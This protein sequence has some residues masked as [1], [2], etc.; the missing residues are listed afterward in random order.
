M[1]DRVR[2][3]L[4]RGDLCHREEE[5][6]QLMGS[7][8]TKLVQVFGIE[9]E[10]TAVLVTGSGTAALEMA[11]SSCLTPKKSMLIVQNGVYGE[12]IA[13][14]AEVYHFEKHVLDYPWGT[15]PKLSDIENAFREHLD[16][17]VVA[18][19][20]HET[21]T[22]LLNPIGPAGELARRYG[23]K[24][25]VD[26]IS[27]LGGDAVDFGAGSIDMAVGTANKCIQG[28]P[29]VS[30]VLFRK[31]DLCRLNNIP[32]RSCYFNLVEHHKA[33]ESGNT[34]FTPAVQS[35]YALE[36]ALEELM[37]ETTAGRIRRYHAAAARFRKG[38]ADMGL[39]CLIPE[40]HRSN[41][42]TALRLPGGL[43]YASLHD[44]LKEKGFVIYAG[45]GNLNSKIFRIANMGNIR[46]GEIDRCLQV[47]RECCAEKI[48]MQG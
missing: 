48:Q 15:P 12:R 46:P 38:F 31:K 19:V 41:C 1:T 27:S 3:A 21:T 24:F 33:Q 42:L 7:I 20:H 40:A 22:G 13:K 39:E 26:C 6:A 2:N 18:M 25:L 43:S 4:L 45:Q 17:E 5:F 9:D 23:K 28:L 34:L 11:V 47:L 30:F 14:M 32:P 35:H 44:G 8:R 29:G 10:Y 37:E 16:I 36:A